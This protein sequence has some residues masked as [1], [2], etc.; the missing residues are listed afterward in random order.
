M[1]QTVKVCLQCGRP[2]F[3]PWVGKISWRRK[4][5]RTPVLWPRKSHGWRKLAGYS[6]WGCKEL[7]TTEQLH[8]LYFL[9]QAL[10]GPSRHSF[11][12]TTLSDGW[13]LLSSS[14]SPAPSSGPVEAPSHDGDREWQVS[15]VFP[16]L[17]SRQGSNQWHKR[18]SLCRVSWERVPP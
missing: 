8:F 18:G 15:L 5:Q 13:P 2:A 17:P 3:N 9:C 6:P 4:W 7:D 14:D 1:A 16:C 10:Q 11:S 12:R